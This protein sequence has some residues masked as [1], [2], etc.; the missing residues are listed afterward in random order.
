[1]HTLRTAAEQAASWDPCLA[2]LA[3][4]FETLPESTCAA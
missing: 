4:I 2:R 3:E 1:V